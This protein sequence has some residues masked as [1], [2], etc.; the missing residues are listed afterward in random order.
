MNTNVFPEAVAATVAPGLLSSVGVAVAIEG[1][2]D[3]SVGVWV[4]FA[5]GEETMVAVPVG[6]LECVASKEGPGDG[7]GVTVTLVSVSVACKEG[8][9]WLAAVGTG[10]PVQPTRKPT[11][12]KNNTPT[13]VYLRIL[14]LPSKR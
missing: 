12:R 8:G 11:M 4:R 3:V 1:A 2:V 5:D 10:V 9:T 14:N 7:I 6:E 13:E